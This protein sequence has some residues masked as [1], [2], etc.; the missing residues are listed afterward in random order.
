MSEQFIAN[1]QK[2]QLS[3][4]TQWGLGVF[5]R[6]WIPLAM[7]V[8]II[9]ICFS[10]FRA[11]TPWAKQYKGEVEQHLST[12][13]G[14]PVNIN[15]METS[16]YWFEPVLKLNQ[17]TL[18]DSKD[19]IL[20]LSKLMVGINLISSLW[21]WHLQPGLL[22]VDDVHLILRQMDN[23][24]Q[25]DGLR[26]DKTV[27]TFDS[28]AYLPVL[29]WLLGQQKIIL[30]N[31][32]A[33]VHFKDGTLLPL[34]ALNLT[35]TNSN[36]HYRF[37]GEVKLAQTMATELL[38]LADL[39]LNADA[40]S[41]ASGHVYLS[42]RRF[43]PKQ[44]QVFIPDLPY[45]LDG[46]RGDFEIWL[47]LWKG[48]LSG[49]QT[50]LNFH[51]VEWV[52][53]NHSPSQFIQSL[54]ANVA[55]KPTAEGWQLSA[56][57]IKLRASGI[58]WPEN[59][60]LIKH[61]S[62]QNKDSVFI[63]SLLIEPLLNTRL[64]WPQ[65]M[66]PVLS[67]HPKG[68]L[69]DT[70][71]ELK[72]GNVHHLLTR[73]D[74][75]S[76]LASKPLPAVEHL[77]GVLSW[78]PNMGRLELD[79]ENTRISMPGL[80][81]LALTQAN[82]A[83]QWKTQNQRLNISM[84]RLILTNK[85][86]VL[87]AKGDLDDPFV[88]ETRHLRLNLELLAD[89][90]PQWLA[91]LPK[92]PSKPRLERWLKQDIKRLDKVEAQLTI[93]GVLADFPFDQKP[94]E[95][96]VLGHLS[97]MD[98][99][100]N[101]LWPIVRDFDAYLNVNKRTLEADVRHAS[102]KGM[103]SEHINFHIDD[104]GLETDTLLLHGQ[105]TV[106]TTK[107]KSYMLLT[108]LKH[109]LSWLEKLAF[110]G[111]V[112]LDLHLDVPL[113]P[114]NNNVLAKGTLGFDNNTVI[115][116]H[117]L[118]DLKLGYLSGDLHFNEQSVSESDLKAQLFDKPLDL[119]F[120]YVP[121]APAYTEVDMRGEATIEALSKQYQLPILS[122][123]KG[124]LNLHS[125]LTIP[126]D[127]KAMNRLELHSSLKGVSVDLPM[128]FKKSAD[129]QA[130][131]TVE[132]DF[133]SEKKS[134]LNMDYDDRIKSQIWF[135][136]QKGALSLDGGL[137][138]VGPGEIP[139]LKRQGLGVV[140][141][142]PSLDVEEWHKVWT[143]LNA[144]SSGT[145][146]SGT[147]Y[148]DMT[149]A[150]LLLWGKVYPKTSIQ[151]SQ[152]GQDGWRLV[153]H[154][155]DVA[156]RL[157]YQTKSNTLAGDFEYLHLAP[158]AKSSQSA[159]P[160]SSTLKPSDIPNLDLHMD[161]LTLGQVDVGEIELK[162]ISTAQNFHLEYCKIKTPEYFVTFKGDWKQA[163]GNNKTALNAELQISDLDKGLDRWKITPAL[164]AKKG[165]IQF[166][167][168]WPSAM[169]DFSLIKTQGNIY[170]ML[171]N[172]R[173]THLSKDTE[174][175]LGLGKLLSVLSL[176]TLP[177]RL[178]LDFSD[179]S[180][181]GYSYDVFKGNFTLNKGVLNT[182]NTYIDGPVAYASIKGNLDLMKQLYDI[183]LHI[184]P[185]I[186]ASLPI[187]ATIAGGPIAGIAV[188]AASKIVSQG[189]Q[190]ITGYTYK[191]SGPW[192]NPVVE[193]MKVFKKQVNQSRPIKSH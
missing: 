146:I 133:H 37:K 114:Q 8:I 16:W 99:Y 92:M 75:L 70:H 42:V 82:A 139:A 191:I 72:E 185:H 106:P 1:P 181:G 79:S 22:Y 155:A 112:G 100:F 141:T 32:S 101:R 116:G 169:N 162:T 80:K 58:L 137:I 49:L 41:K 108:P 30:K 178:K 34:S 160:V 15:S 138:L 97:G 73:F 120:N 131:L 93:N 77:S 84:G 74:D 9:A 126:D 129:A 163:Q 46:G 170:M 81:P 76:W 21:H 14:Q 71:V 182:S 44:W 148:A 10:V 27:T 31:V 61:D 152:Q 40:L 171:E 105:M 193:Q 59:A 127:L 57:Q 62:L 188:W 104:M 28:D 117:A 134:K 164:D 2:K 123:M 67:L 88:P 78:Q 177:R 119:H 153:I 60:L 36:G 12:L 150:E 124:H 23:R 25:V 121:Q 128:P 26:Q 183:D 175:K 55:W 3:T 111:N 51:R 151:A 53:D 50:L 158:I 122:F 168:G 140:G 173:I 190:E 19:H 94:G 103:V 174:E 13:I 89:N 66:Q 186:T 145:I 125:R 165:Y 95:F 113:N 142:L 47:D 115:F 147:T 33:L 144:Q 107:L 45:H 18:E 54:K 48:Q 132:F 20:K 90:A 5:K 85:D 109:R 83:F 65:M 176:Q 7:L 156:C 52:K 166:E 4:L 56:D 149:F 24:W 6:C 96:V 102:L 91:Y 43:L 130:P 179:L 64:E 87:N 192:L 161:H 29:G 172:G 38:M 136:N 98:F 189:M 69:H 86:L 159:H 35:A 154:Q 157:N 110:K 135:A 180:K 184:S 143:Q 17:V 39:Q 68:E 118:N 63:K 187:V 167:G 11:L